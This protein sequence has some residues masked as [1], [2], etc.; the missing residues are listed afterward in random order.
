MSIDAAKEKILRE[1]DLSQYVGQTVKLIRRSGNH[2]GLCPFHEEKSPSF[3]VFA[4]NYYCFGCQE[5]GDVITFAMKTKGL[6][7]IDALKFLAAHHGL[8]V[9]DLD[10]RKKSSAED[11]AR[12]TMFRCLQTAQEYFVRHLARPEAEAHRRYLEGRGFS[13][14]QIISYGFGFAPEGGGLTAA[15]RGL[16]IAM[17]DIEKA[18]LGYPGKYGR[19]GGYD[20]FQSRIMIPI[21]D[22]FGRIIAFGG[23]T[24][25]DHPAKYKNSKE[26]AV[27]HKSRT[28]YGA[29][30]AASPARKSNRVIVTEGYMDAL[31]LWASGIPETVAVLGTALTAQHMKALARMATT[32]FL[33]FDGDRAG[34]RAGLKSVEA[35]LTVPGLNIKVLSLPDGHD[36]DSF[37]TERGKEAFLAALSSS[38]E[39]FQFAIRH[40]LK[41]HEG[42]QVAQVVAGTILPWL[43]TIKDPITRSF[44][45]T[46]L[47]QTTGIGQ[48][49]LE[50][51]MSPQ[52]GGPLRSSG[53]V[54]PSTVSGANGD[55]PA[56]EGAEPVNPGPEGLDRLAVEFLAHVYFLPA[57]F[58][59]EALVEEA[60]K[61]VVGQRA[62][63][64]ALVAAMRQKAQAIGVL[65]DS[66]SF[67]WL[68]GASEAW[69][70]FFAKLKA[71]REFF[72][73]EDPGR[74]IDMLMVRCQLTKIKNDISMLKAQLA[75][76]PNSLE[77]LAALGQLTGTRLSLESRLS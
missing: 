70:P 23:R 44:L 29:D 16:G 18:S 4:K 17:A 58:T 36:P 3:T 52:A 64:L 73:T 48:Q 5:S 50:A 53:A 13:P 31:K 71:K 34:I 77:I 40:T 11:R 8:D 76:E 75:A 38:E 60:A 74:A 15:L 21:K 72:A 35:A 39:L 54:G 57:A 14:E 66:A 32:V 68:A 49:T 12:A 30:T 1:I 46:K 67:D 69:L 61:L 28:L 26:T 25:T 7:F 47:A 65:A 22:S 51:Q 55:V 9:G 45:L 6:S 63:L 2:V 42:I 10:R 19:D 59:D 41:E 20:F 62:D 24:V 56:D 37:V 33:V 43:S 27:F